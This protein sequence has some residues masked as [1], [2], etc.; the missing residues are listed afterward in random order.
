MAPKEEKG[1]L[2]KMMLLT[3]RCKRSRQEDGAHEKREAPSRKGWC[4]WEDDIVL[5]KKEAPFGGQWYLR[6]ERNVLR[7]RK[8]LSRRRKKTPLARERRPQGKDDT[9]K[10]RM[11]PW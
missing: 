11:V 5:G 4:P 9:L 8:E 2:G 10:K 3:K 7:K 6:K 1:A